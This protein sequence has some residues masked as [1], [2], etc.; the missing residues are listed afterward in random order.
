MRSSPSAGSI[1]AASCRDGLYQSAP[2]VFRLFV[3]GANHLDEITFEPST[4]KRKK[5]TGFGSH[6][7]RRKR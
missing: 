6:P 4:G 3:V 5:R 2:F 1:S 7:G